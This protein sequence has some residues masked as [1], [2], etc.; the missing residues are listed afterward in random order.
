MITSLDEPIIV[1]TDKMIIIF[2]VMADN[3]QM[4]DIKIIYYFI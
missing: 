2:L 3:R 1:D 4:A